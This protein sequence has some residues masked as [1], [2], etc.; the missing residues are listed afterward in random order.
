MAGDFRPRSC[1]QRFVELKAG[2]LAW[3][4]GFR[5][6]MTFLAVLRQNMKDVRQAVSESGNSVKRD[7][8]HYMLKLVP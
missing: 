1:V 7:Q 5:G 2:H 3:F 6:Y 8:R 4:A